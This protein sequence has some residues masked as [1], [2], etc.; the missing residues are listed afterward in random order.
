MANEFVTNDTTDLSN[1]INDGYSIVDD[2]TGDIY[3]ILERRGNVVRLDK[4]WAGSIA[5]WVWTI[6][7]PVSFLPSGT[8]GRYPC[9]GVYQ[10]IIRF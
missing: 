3:R 10:K 6:P 8:S 4:N 1:F 2:K 9:I 5:Q 7:A